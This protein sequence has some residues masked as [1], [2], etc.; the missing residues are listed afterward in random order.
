MTPTVAGRRRYRRLT[1][2]NAAARQTSVL[3]RAK[4]GTVETFPNWNFAEALLL[5]MGGS[6]GEQGQLRISRIRRS[7]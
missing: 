1:K 6:A 2:V 4:I 5:P 7:D 3:R